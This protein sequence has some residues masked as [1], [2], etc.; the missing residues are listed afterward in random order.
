MAYELRDNSGTLF[1][2][3]R[4]EEGDNKPHWEG[5]CMVNGVKMRVAAWTKQGAKGEFH[6]LKFSLPNEHPRD[7]ESTHHTRRP[8]SLPGDIQGDDGTPW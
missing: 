3:R 6:S 1:K 8:D 5:D 4:K 7:G 2:N